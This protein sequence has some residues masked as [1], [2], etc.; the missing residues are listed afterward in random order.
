MNLQNLLLKFDWS[1][2]SLYK[3]TNNIDKRIIEAIDSTFTVKDG[4]FS[5]YMMPYFWGTLG[6]LYNP[7]F[8]K[9]E[10]LNKGWGL[11]WNENNNPGLVG[12]IA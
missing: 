6:I 11:L 8:V 1:D 10:D 7:E 5:D 3:N 2:A 9:E 4:K 12:K